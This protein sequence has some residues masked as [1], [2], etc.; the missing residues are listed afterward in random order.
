MNSGRACRHENDLKKVKDEAAVHIYSAGQLVMH[1]CTLNEVGTE[2][3]MTQ[4]AGAVRHSAWWLLVSEGSMASVTL[5]QSQFLNSVVK[6]FAL[7]QF[8]DDDPKACDPC[9]YTADDG[10]CIA[11][12]THCV[13][14]DYK[15]CGIP[16]SRKHKYSGFPSSM[17]NLLHVLEKVKKVEIR[18]CVVKDLTI[19]SKAGPGLQLGIVNSSFSPPLNTSILTIQ[20]PERCDENECAH[21]CHRQ[22]LCDPRS[23]CFASSTG[24]G[25]Q[26]SCDNP[27]RNITTRP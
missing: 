5:N 11:D 12:R 9:L 19:E 24:T 23:L 22:E 27:R 26:C 21:N 6:T 17:G 3:T 2:A 14:G 16:M 15:D 4:T 1:R 25:V 7:C 10:I 18:S 13:V 20:A 8:H